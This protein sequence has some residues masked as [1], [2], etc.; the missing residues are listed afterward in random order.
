MVYEIQMKRVKRF[1]HR[2]EKKRFVLRI[3]TFNIAFRNKDNILNQIYVKPICSD[4]Y[5]KDLNFLND[6]K[7]RTW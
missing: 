5:Y 7:K 4:F 6:I 3:C 1:I 2:G